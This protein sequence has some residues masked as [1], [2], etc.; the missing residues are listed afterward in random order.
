MTPDKPFFTE[1]DVFYTSQLQD[2][3][4]MK[5]VRLEDAN[6]KV[7][8]LLPKCVCGTHSLNTV[9]REDG[10]CFSGHGIACE[11]H[12]LHHGVACGI[13]LDA[14]KEENERLKADIKSWHNI[15]DDAELAYQSDC[16]EKKALEARIAKLE[17]EKLRDNKRAQWA[18][19]RVNILEEAL[20]DAAEDLRSL[21]NCGGTWASFAREAHQK[22]RAAL[23]EGK[24]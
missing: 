13:C 15:H 12:D 2:G 14:L 4:I 6:A 11:V 8:P 3:T 22:A 17:E 19:D 7:A 9:H 18:E 1:E 20:R 5:A 24:E 10:P 16:R 23:G 21:E